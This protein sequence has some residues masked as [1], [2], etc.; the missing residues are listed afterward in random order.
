MKAMILAQF[1]SPII[2]EEIVNYELYF[3]LRNE[4]LVSF[5]SHSSRH[6]MSIG[7]HNNIYR[8]QTKSILLR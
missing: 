7:Y 2:D 3:R 4:K 8:Y 6:S 1:A 5:P